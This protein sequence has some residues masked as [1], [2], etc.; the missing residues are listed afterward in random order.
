MYYNNTHTDDIVYEYSGESLIE[1]WVPVSFLPMYHVSNL[2]RIKSFA[3]NK[4]N[5][6]KQSRTKDG[7]LRVGLTLDGKNKRFLSH[8]LT[9]SHFVKNEF[10][11]P[12]VNHIDGIRDNNVWWN[13]AWATDSDQQNHSYKVLGRQKYLQ[14][15]TGVLHPMYGR[16]GSLSKSNKPVFCENN[17]RTYI[18]ATQA[19]NE[20]GLKLTSLCEVARGD[21]KTIHGYKFNYIS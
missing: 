6:K 21:K 9:A 8:R 15:K 18:S 3:K 20:L 14:G 2:G 11:K 19:A 12:E 13:L 4:V 16:S 5:I 7:Y 1:T 17:G 10:N